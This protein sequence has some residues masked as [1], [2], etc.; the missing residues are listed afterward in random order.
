MEVF[1][2]YKAEFA[3]FIVR[4]IAGILFFVQGYDKV[5]RLKLK[6]T[7]DAA[8][9]A[10]SDLRIPVS[11]IRLITVTTSILELTGGLM[12]IIGLFII[13]SC[14]VLALC[15]LPITIAMSLREP[16]WNMR[17]IWGR[18]VLIIFLLLMPDSLHVISV[19]HL[20]GVL[21]R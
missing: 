1:I 18:L 10:L 20:I 19:D 7:E 11:M 21:R 9:Y 6:Q 2:E 3:V 5:F 15:L 8:I 14:Y 13:P 16:M 12:L 4:L 17:L